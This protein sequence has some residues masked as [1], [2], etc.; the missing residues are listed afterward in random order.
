MQSGVGIVAMDAEMSPVGEVDG[1][2]MRIERGA[3]QPA[4]G[5]QYGNLNRGYAELRHL[6][7]PF[8]E[9]EV[10]PFRLDAAGEQVHGGRHIVHHAADLLLEGGRKI[11]GI[12]AGA[13]QGGH[14]LLANVG[15]HQPDDRQADEQ[16]EGGH[17]PFQR[18]AGRPDRLGAGADA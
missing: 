8:R 12:A 5:A 7:R 4:V 6:A 16:A 18:P 17:P 14:A 11:G 2:G 15:G 3:E 13:L 9:V 1:R 10:H